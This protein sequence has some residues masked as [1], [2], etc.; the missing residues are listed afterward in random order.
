VLGHGPILGRGESV[1]E[2]RWEEERE[3][4]S[5]IGSAGEKARARSVEKS[6][7]G[8]KGRFFMR[9]REKVR[10]LGARRIELHKKGAARKGPYFMGP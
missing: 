2:I 1:P 8:E 3:I 7:F 6:R 5:Y 9:G 10:T 4:R